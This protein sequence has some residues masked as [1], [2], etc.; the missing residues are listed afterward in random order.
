MLHIRAN[1]G[2]RG[3]PRSWLAT[4]VALA[5]GLAF[6]TALGGLARPAAAQTTPGAN[7]PFTEYNAVNA[8]TNGTIRGP[9]YSFGS[10]PSEA[11]GRE[12][13]LLAARAS[14]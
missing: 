7:V 10:L 3:W 14:T 4:V 9:D 13:D 5:A 1:G 2:S 8:A 11:T 12:V 6:L